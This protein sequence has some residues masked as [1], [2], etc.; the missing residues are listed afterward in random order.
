VTNSLDYPQTPVDP[1]ARQFLLWAL[2]MLKLPVERAGDEVFEVRLPPDKQTECA[3]AEAI[4]FSFDAGHSADGSESQPLTLLSPLGEQLLEWLRAS[5]TVA[6]A[7]PKEQPASVHELT[8]RL[9]AAYHVESGTVRLGGCRLEDRPLLRYTY[10]VRTLQGNSRARLVHLYAA[11][12][13]RPLDGHLVAALGLEELTPLDTPPP[14]VSS[15]DLFHWLDFAEKHAP[16]VP[17]NEQVELL[18]TTVIWCK[19]VCGKLLFEIG[20]GRGEMTFQGW[21]ELL[22]SGAVAPPPFR[23]PQTGRESYDLVATVDGRVSVPEAL[24]SCEE[25][26]QEVLESDL[27][28]CAVTGRRVLPEYLT[29]CP[30][31]GKRVLPSTLIACSQCQQQVSPLVVR[32]G[33]CQACRS[34]KPV[35][36][37]DPKLARVLGE[38][39]HLDQWLR[40]RMAETASVYILIASSFLRRLLLVLDKDTLEVAHLADGFRF[41]RKWKDVSEYERDEYLG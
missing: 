39:G 40:W 32:D 14:R 2:A 22:A 8:A 41:S 33:L 5:R 17:D 11:V 30:V 38:Y 20:A 35:S 36:R 18:L 3:G 26:G 4:R 1:L 37:E 13:D 34:L 15:D 7:T 21:A 23:C 27:Q 12:D 9:F 29:P 10:R 6:H 28:T 31:S 25:S 16:V 19:H 24:A